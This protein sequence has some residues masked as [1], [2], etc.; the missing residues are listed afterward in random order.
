MTY[1]RT[2]AAVAA[3]TVALTLAPQLV[4]V[5]VADTNEHRHIEQVAVEPITP[6]AEVVAEDVIDGI[7][8]VADDGSREEFVRSAVAKFDR[9]GWSLTNTEV[10]FDDTCENAV[11][12]HAE[13]DGHHVVVMCT[14]AEWTLL[15]ELGHV[16]SDLYLDEG[17]RSEWLELRGLDSWTVGTEHVADII[18]FGLFDSTHVPTSIGATDYDSVTEAFEWLMGMTPFHRQRNKGATTS[19]ESTARVHVVA[20]RTLAP[21][22]ATVVD[23]TS[24]VRP[25]EY[26]FPLGCGYPR[27]HSSHGGY[28]YTDPRDWTHVGVDLYA[29]EGTPVVSPVHGTVVDAGFND[30]AGWKVAVEDRFGYTHRMAHLSAAPLVT[31][32]MTVVAGQPL[33]NVG[34]S[35]NASG[36]GPHLHYEVRTDGETIDPMPWLIDTGDGHVAPAPRSFFSTQASEWSGCETRA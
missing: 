31:E 16:W 5:A 11:G 18:A 2:I 13:E 12:Y 14:D 1:A 8:I 29:F 26:R 4:E 32:G 30:I 15:H 19:H 3:A 25:V 35:G 7:R 22:D 21:A 27:W 24:Q 34:R 10:R 28:G 6:L 20:P 33:G 36:G 23:V 9:A 17:E